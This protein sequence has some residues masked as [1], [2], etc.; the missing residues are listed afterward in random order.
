MIFP[1]IV[2]AI[3][4]GM[5]AY[6]AF[7]EIRLASALGR[8][9]VEC[10]GII[11]SQREVKPGRRSNYFEPR[12]RFETATGEVIEGESVGAEWVLSTRGGILSNKVEFFDNSDAYLRYDIRDPSSFL[13]VQ[14]LNQS[15]RYLQLAVTSLVALCMLLV[16]L[17]GAIPD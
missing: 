12:V 16:G 8:E 7:K 11:V 2:C 9:G 10:S 1:A 15:G 13:F 6:G 14:E 5:G 3:I 4:P 17:F